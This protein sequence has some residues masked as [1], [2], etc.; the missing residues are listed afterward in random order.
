MHV[1]LLLDTVDERLR[2][3]RGHLLTLT[4][5]ATGRTGLVLLHRELKVKIVDLRNN[6]LPRQAASSL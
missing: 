6:I 1:V 3:V 4:V 2:L 5:L